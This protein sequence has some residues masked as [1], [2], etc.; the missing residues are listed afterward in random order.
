MYH[1]P[2]AFEFSSEL[3]IFIASEM[4]SNKFG[5]FIQNCEKQKQ[6]LKLAELTESMWTY[7]LTEKHRFMNKFYSGPQPIISQINL[8]ASFTLPPWREFFYKW[9][10]FGYS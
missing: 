4:Y 2:L 7:V 3:L 1:H 5:T 9:T 8:T 10:E 6:T